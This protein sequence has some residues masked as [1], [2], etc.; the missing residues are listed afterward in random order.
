MLAERSF[1]GQA[2][3]VSSAGCVVGGAELVWRAFVSVCEELEGNAAR[4]LENG[5][6]RRWSGRSSGGVEGEALSVRRCRV[7]V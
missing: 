1:V 3:S 4:I 7:V 5:G 2:A 6:F